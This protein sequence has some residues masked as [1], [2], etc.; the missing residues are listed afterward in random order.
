MI[1]DKTGKEIRSGD[2]VSFVHLGEAYT[3]VVRDLGRRLQSPSTGNVPHVS[4]SIE[5]H[6]PAAACVVVATVDRT[7]AGEEI[8][9]SRN[10]R[11][12]QR[13]ATHAQ[14]PHKEI[15]S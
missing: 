10:R 15:R 13:A 2:T 1:Q 6:I 9:L 12:T 14:S 11:A 3:A 5:A 8:A 4:V 7:E